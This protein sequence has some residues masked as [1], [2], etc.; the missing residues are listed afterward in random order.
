MNATFTSAYNRSDWILR[1]ASLDAY[2]GQMIRVRFRAIQASAWTKDIWMLDDL[3]IGERQTQSIAFPFE[4]LVADTTAAAHWLPDGQWVIVNNAG[5]GD[6]FS[7]SLN[8]MDDYQRSTNFALTLNAGISLPADATNLKFSHYDRLTL[9]SDTNAYVEIST[10]PSTPSAGQVAQTWTTLSTFK[11]VN[12]TTTWTQREVSLSAYAGQTVMLRWRAA[13]GAS[14]TKD[15]WQVD[16]LRI[17]GD[18][19]PTATPTQTP[20]PSDTPTETPTLTPETTESPTPT[21]TFT[22]SQAVTAIMDQVS[23]YVANGS[24]QANLQNSLNSKLTNANKKLEKGQVNAAVNE[25]QAFINAVQAQRGK[26]I[27]VEAA[28]ALI[29]QAQAVIAQLTPTP[30]PTLTPSPSPIGEGGT[31]LAFLPEGVFAVSLKLPALPKIK[32]AAPVSLFQQQSASVT[33]DYA[34]DPLYRL[35]A[36]DYSTGDFYHYAY[37]SVGN[38]LTQESAVNGLPSTVNYQYDIANRLT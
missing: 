26:K 8:P 10:D 5:N 28:D 15:I 11:A 27:T 23:V 16:N 14:W 20:T 35:T 25:L 32:S 19:A 3:R 31:P 2:K 30:T 37:D 34:Y 12:N 1:R 7:W 9:A 4:D 38:R 21:A 17:S 6:T 36:A 22:P 13:Q 18:L 24:I 29:A 33:I